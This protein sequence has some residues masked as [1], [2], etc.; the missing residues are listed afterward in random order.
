MKPTFQNISEEKKERVISAC[1]EEFGTHGY[2][3]SSMDG[4]IHRAGIS[5][6]GLYEYVASKRDLFLYTVEYSYKKLYDYLNI[7]LKQDKRKPERD[8]LIKLRQVAEFAIDFYIENPQYIFLIV[9]TSY[10]TDDG[11]AGEVENIFGKHFFDLF[12]N[13][14]TS[15]LAYPKEK[16]IELAMWLLQKTR[17]DFLNEFKTEKN[18]QKIKFDYMKNWNFYLGIMAGGIYNI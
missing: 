9:K 3:S 16:V 10:L 15:Q 5:K 12:G 8:L 4:V 13:T 6:G 11:L 17:L 18:P 7:R 1:I 14:D 2:E